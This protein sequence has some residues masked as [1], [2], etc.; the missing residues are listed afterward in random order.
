MSWWG[1]GSGQ[2]AVSLGNA[3]AASPTDRSPLTHHQPWGRGGSARPAP[4][5]YS[6][7][8]TAPPE[9]APRR[10]AEAKKPRSH[11]TGCS[12]TRG[13]LLCT[14]AESSQSWSSTSVC[15]A[16]CG[17]APKSP[18][19]LHPMPSSLPFAYE[20]EGRPPGQSSPARLIKTALKRGALRE[21]GA[22]RESSLQPSKCRGW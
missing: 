5:P 16:G 15:G 14:K 21:N 1:R 12:A 18:C 19:S 2:D 17:V 9:S 4:L 22:G 20:W 8:P 10:E 6:A 7:G 13:R 11:P 3:P